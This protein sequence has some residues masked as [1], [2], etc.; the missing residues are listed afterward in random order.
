[1]EKKEVEGRERSQIHTL[2]NR[3]EKRAEDEST[4]VANVQY[5]KIRKRTQGGGNKRED[6][7]KEEEK[8]EIEHGQKERKRKENKSE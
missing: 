5:R 1:M 7:R 6:G 2:Q 3:A 4:R 8:G